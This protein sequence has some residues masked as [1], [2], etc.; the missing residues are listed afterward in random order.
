MMR[1]ASLRF[2]SAVL[3]GL[4]LV[5][6]LMPAPLVAQL[7][8]EEYLHE[9]KANAI[10]GENGYKQRGGGGEDDRRCEGLFDIAT[11]GRTPE[12]AVV[13]LTLGSI[14]FDL[15]RSLKLAIAVPPWARRPADEIALR[16]LPLAEG[17]N[18]QLDAVVPTSG[19]FVWPAGTLLE[20]YGLRAP[21]LGA[22]A[23][24]HAQ[25]HP[26]F[27]PVS[28]REGGAQAPWAEPVPQKTQPLSLL[29]RY[30]YTLARLGWRSGTLD[31]AGE[32]VTDQPF[33]NL[34]GP[35]QGRAPILIDLSNATGNCLAFR[36]K[37]SGEGATSEL[38]VIRLMLPAGPR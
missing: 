8:C 1:S 22:Y 19:V 31:G 9:I 6:C 15:K 36:I 28:V 11:A 13:S 27:I 32:C 5:L 37:R 17:K 25:G 33:K 30:P 29:V 7:R 14:S 23:V 20:P 24:K 21:L 12:L 16:V 35:L 26:I 4:G 10:R 34:A 18:Y 38:V 3:M 2:L